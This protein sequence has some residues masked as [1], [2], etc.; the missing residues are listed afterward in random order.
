[1][2]LRSRAVA[3]LLQRLDNEADAADP[4]G[5]F[6]SARDAPLDAGDM[7]GEMNTHL[8][9][10]IAVAL[11]GSSLL[12]ST[13]GSSVVDEL[14]DA[15]PE[16]DHPQL[17]DGRGR[18]GSISS[19]SSGAATA[20]SRLAPRHEAGS[21]GAQGVW[22]DGSHAQK[23]AWASE[24][25]APHAGLVRAPG[26]IRVK[27]AHGASSADKMGCDIISACA[28][29]AW[30]A[31]CSDSQC[32]RARRIL[33]FIVLQHRPEECA[34]PRAQ[35]SHVLSCQLY[36][37]SVQLGALS[38][39][40][41]PHGLVWFAQTTCVTSSSERCIATRLAMTP[42]SRKTTTLPRAVLRVQR[43]T[44]C[45]VERW[46]SWTRCTILMS[47]RYRIEQNR[48]SLQSRTQDVVISMS[49]QLPP[50]KNRSFCHPIIKAINLNVHIKGSAAALASARLG[51]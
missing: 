51:S 10:D 25:A 45:C 21:S 11:G 4:S 13:R 36:Q 18:S 17:H 43:C 48:G 28:G 30:M 32:E 9:A 37:G 3:D 47:S 29:G 23:V 5:A 20:L 39:P 49:S 12:P 22:R 27:P 34:R 46:I 44:R 14:D 7:G 40:P 16:F 35:D 26:V 1:M 38:S 6:Y 50:A 33:D 2:P 41:Y 31:E 8:P 19:K 24:L 15:E 42:S